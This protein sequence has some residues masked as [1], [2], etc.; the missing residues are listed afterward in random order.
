MIWRIVM[1]LLGVH[2]AST[3]KTPP[4][5]QEARRVSRILISGARASEDPGLIELAVN[6][7]IAKANCC[8][9]PGNVDQLFD[10]LEIEHEC[11]AT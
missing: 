2:L 6:L 9:Y 7:K 1:G 4:L 3:W 10:G 8:H 5:I 11:C